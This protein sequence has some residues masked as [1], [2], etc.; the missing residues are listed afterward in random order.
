[1]YCV[2]ED[3]PLSEEDCDSLVNVLEMM[4]PLSRDELKL[5][6]DQVNRAMQ[7]LLSH[8]GVLIQSLLYQ[9]YICRQ[10]AHTHTAEDSSIT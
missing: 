5:F 9:T 3:G 8:V 10:D 7:C 1:M 4:H 6:L 2:D